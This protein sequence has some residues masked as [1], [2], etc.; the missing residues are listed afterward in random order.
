[1]LLDVL[2]V[3][4]SGVPDARCHSA[5]IE[6][7]L[8]P[9][10]FVCRLITGEAF[11]SPASRRTAAVIRSR[12]PSVRYVRAKNWTGSPYSSVASPATTL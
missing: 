11:L 6:C 2:R 1:M 9:P 5:S 8:P 12:R 10:K 7:V 3:V 4:A